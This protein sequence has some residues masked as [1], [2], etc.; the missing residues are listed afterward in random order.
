[1][2]GKRKRGGHG[3]KGKGGG[4]CG[5]GA[6]GAG[7]GKGGEDL[8]EDGEDVGSEVKRG[9]FGGRPDV[10]RED[11]G[12]IEQ[13]NASF[14]AYYQRQRICPVEEWPRLLETLRTGLPAA[15]R[16]NRMRAGAHA[17]CTRLEELQRTCSGDAERNCYA[18]Q[19]LTWY[20]HGLA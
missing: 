8:D 2:G 20:P 11:A 5:K 16:V 9:K 4:G 10:W 14:E 1:M 13:T 17:L 18:P 6:G 7:A 15:I 12:S 19:L 3:G